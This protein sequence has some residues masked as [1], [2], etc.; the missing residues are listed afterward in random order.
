MVGLRL[1]LPRLVDQPPLGPTDE[2]VPGVF[3]LPFAL[4]ERVD[5]D[6]GMQPNALLVRPPNSHRERIK[7]GI[8]RVGLVAK[9]LFAPGFERGAVV[10]VGLP[11]DLPEDIGKPGL[12][13]LVDRPLDIDR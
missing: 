4:P 13:R 6:P 7:A 1:G 2:G 10:G 5:I 9:E 12:G 3:G 11:P 8:G